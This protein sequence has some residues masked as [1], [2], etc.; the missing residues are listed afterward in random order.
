MNKIVRTLSLI[1]TLMIASL[2]MAAG[3]GGTD[4]RPIPPQ[5][6]PTELAAWNGPG[7]TDPRPIPPQVNLGL[8]NE[9]SA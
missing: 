9:G 3:P 1:S 8:E 2:M 6:M 4:P 7:G 5:M